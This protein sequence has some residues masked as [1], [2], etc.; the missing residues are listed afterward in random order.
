MPNINKLNREMFD[1][2]NQEKNI[3]RAPEG[4][5]EDVI[6]QISKDKNEPEWMLQ[7]RLN[8]LRYFN[9][10]AVPEW[11]PSL[12]DLNLDKISFYVKPDSKTNS[13]SWEEVPEDIKRT[14]ERLGIPKAEREALAGAGA[15]YDSDVVYHNLKKEWEEKGV[16]FEDC[17]DALQK[18]PKLIKEYFMTK[19]IPINDHKF[20]MLHG[21]VWSG[22]TLIYV[23]KN[24]KVDI[25]LQAYFRMNSMKMGQ[26]E[27]TL[28]IADEGSELHYIEGCFT[29]GNLITCNPDYKKIEDIKE[30]QKVLTNDGSYKNVK[31]TFMMP[32]SGNLYKL[33]VY[34]N[35]LDNMD[36]TEDHPFLYADKKHKNDRNKI[37]TP[38]WNI[39]KFFKKGDYLVVPINKTIIS[40]NYHEVEIKEWNNKNKRF[41]C[42]TENIPSTKDFFRLAG[43]YLA[44]GSIS[45]GYYLNFSFSS[46]ERN[47]IEDVKDL[48]ESIFNLKSIEPH[49]KSNNGTNVVVCSVNL[50][51]IFESLFGKRA[52]NKSIPHWMILEDTEKQKEL[53]KSYFKGDGNYY[54]KKCKSGFKEVF[55][56]NSVSE[57]L[58]RQCK[59]ILLRLGIISFINSR[60][61]SKEGRQVMYTLGMT[62][63]YMKK[64]GEIVGFEINS[65]IN[66][67]NMASIF[68]IT[69]DFAF[70]PIRKIEKREVKDEIVYNF[71]VE[72]N[73]TYCVSGVVAHNCSSPIYN[74]NSIHAGCVEIYVKKN[75][76]VRYSSIENWSKNTYNLNTKRAIVEENGIIEW[77]SGNM[78]SGVTMLYPSSILKGRNS[79]A[80]H[81]SIAF[82]GKG[83]NQD[84]GAKVFHLNVNTSSNI[85]SKSIS[86]DGGTTSYR[87][88]VKIN[89]G[90]KGSRSSVECDA[91]MIDNKSISNTYPFID[92]KEKNVDV[93]HEATVGKISDEQIFYLMSR[94]LN[95]EQAKQIVVSGFIEPIIKQLPL[96]YAAELNKLIELEM[97]GSLG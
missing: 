17:D 9:K 86:I 72:D 43:Y 69:P 78:G 8:A 10:T 45:G 74:S 34:G 95:E 80:D 40:K 28:I 82:A 67:K 37:F 36:V 35:S 88:L 92:V 50:C 4:L 71:S 64:F 39:P 31:E 6:R 11:G 79:K 52:N 29:R 21:A 24:V 18:Y 1:H 58:V 38:R 75:A 65:R 94:G 48:V 56:I 32:Y 44:E 77:I 60:D 5:N 55:R 12:K 70:F 90:C 59:D 2:A 16:V 23:P 51:R 27:H 66:D 61:R 68:G 89:K 20:I 30:G 53:I 3:Y 26:F 42:L 25:P 7:K 93:A 14:F 15:Q 96:E 76:R 46:K 19:C 85:Q 54:K 87:G 49:H 97:E 22:G 84:T 91:L 13:K 57:K 41:N 83:Q 33:Q 81:I 47:L 62:G 73:E 63:E